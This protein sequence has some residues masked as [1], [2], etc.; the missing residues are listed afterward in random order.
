MSELNNQ[1]KAEEEAQRKAR[2]E[3]AKKWADEIKRLKE[4][5]QSLMQSMKGAVMGDTYEYKV[6]EAH[7]VNR[8]EVAKLTEEYRKHAISKKE[9]D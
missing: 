1:I 6:A 3:A 9:L 8:E 2:E 5:Y 4:E 7:R